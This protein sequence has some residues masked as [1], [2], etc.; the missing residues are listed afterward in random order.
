[1]LYS[2]ITCSYTI[3]NSLKRKQFLTA[4]FTYIWVDILLHV[5]RTDIDNP[6]AIET[7][8]FC[9]FIKYIKIFSTKYFKSNI[10]NSF[11]REINHKSHRMLYSSLHLHGWLKEKPCFALVG[12]IAASVKLLCKKTE[13]TELLWLNRIASCKVEVR[14]DPLMYSIKSLS[15]KKRNLPSW[16]VIIQLVVSLHYNY[17]VNSSYLINAQWETSRV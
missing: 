3:S 1:L 7:G 9:A 4:I 13:V 10:W 6:D 11:W 2:V 12:E 16:T 15:F 14:N 17:S 8:Y 5:S